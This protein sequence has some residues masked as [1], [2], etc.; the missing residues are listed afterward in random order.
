MRPGGRQQHVS[1]IRAASLVKGLGAV[2][3][4]YMPVTRFPAVRY[5]SSVISSARLARVYSI[6]VLTNSGRYV[7]L[8]CICAPRARMVGTDL[9]RAAVASRVAVQMVVFFSARIGETRSSR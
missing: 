9:G 5:R 8:K 3:S 7:Y 6:G 1:G 4:L 2:A